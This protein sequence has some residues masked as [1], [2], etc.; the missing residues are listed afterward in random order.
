M[1]G[2]WG[3]LGNSLVDQPVCKQRSCTSS[4]DALER[5]TA[6]EACVDQ[7]VHG[8]AG[9]R[10]AADVLDLWEVVF[11]VVVR[12]G[13]PTRVQ[14]R[15]IAPCSVGDQACRAILAVRRPKAK[16]GEQPGHRTVP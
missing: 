16:A 4:Y 9:G 3:G 6:R 14:N 12:H 15:L 11:V 5:R 10:V 2:N 8:P 7:I 13:A 1:P